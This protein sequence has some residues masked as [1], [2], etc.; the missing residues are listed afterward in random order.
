MAS[1]L[2]I[3]SNLNPSQIGDVVNNI[4]GAGAAIG[5]AKAMAGNILSKA[6]DAKAKLTNLKSTMD[7]GKKELEKI[8]NVSGFLKDQTKLSPADVKNILVAAALP[9]LTKF[10]NTEKVANLLLDKLTNEA[11]KKLEKYGRVEISGGTII[12]TPKSKGD[13]EKFAKNFK[14]KV[15]ALKTAVAALK[16]IIDT[17]VTL[18]KVVRAGLV[19]LKVYIAL[20]KIKLKTMAAAAATEAALP[21]PSKPANAAYL[22]FKEATDPIINVLEKK[23]DDYILMT[24]VISS[25][26]S[27]FKKMIDKIKE[28]LDK[29]NIIINDLPDPSKSLST[30]LNTTT[31]TTGQQTPED[32]EDAKGNHYTI[33]VITTPSGAIQVTAYDKNTNLKIAETAPSKTRGADKLLDEIKQILG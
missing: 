10:I 17:L 7:K 20:L 29:I 5:G 13:F 8:K 25:I 28:K 18:L 31:P 26:L 22:A 11:K 33:R 1:S 30:E 15:D 19:A 16:K 12:F 24:T 14:R 23:V 32:Y 21:T 2:S 9:L 6:D 3:P 27:I 4:P